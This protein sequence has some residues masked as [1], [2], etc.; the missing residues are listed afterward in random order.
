MRRAFYS[1]AL[2]LLGLVSG[3]GEEGIAEEEGAMELEKIDKELKDFFSKVG[4]EF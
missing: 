1:G 4:K 3:L 2:I